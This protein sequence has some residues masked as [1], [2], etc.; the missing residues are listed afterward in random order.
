MAG[1]IATR[2]LPQLLTDLAQSPV[3]ESGDRPPV[4]SDAKP[5]VAKYVPDAGT[6]GM[7]EGLA[8][9][10]GQR[11]EAI[12]VGFS[13]RQFL[14][15]RLKGELFSLTG[16]AC[17]DKDSQTYMT[18]LMGVGRV[19]EDLEKKIWKSKTTTPKTNVADADLESLHPAVEAKVREQN[20][21]ASSAEIDR[22]VTLAKNVLH[23]LARIANDY[24]L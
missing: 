8:E 23:E 4:E 5:Y 17:K 11:P 22:M 14:K 1:A 18:V 2:D 10:G 19:L 24:K 9:A 7:L 15:D 3:V 6:I 20:P 13:L 21:G 12:E 16:T